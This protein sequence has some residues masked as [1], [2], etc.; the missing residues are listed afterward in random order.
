MLKPNCY[1]C[2]FRGNVPIDCH[3]SCKNLNATVNV[4]KKK[5]VNE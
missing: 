4:F 5:E 3:S 2:I 1:E